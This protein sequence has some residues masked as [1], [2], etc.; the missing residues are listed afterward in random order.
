MKTVTTDKQAD[1]QRN[2]LGISEIYTSVCYSIINLTY[3]L[4]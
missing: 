2:R 3:L 1:G 4:K